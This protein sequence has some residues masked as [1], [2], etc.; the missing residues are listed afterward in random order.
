VIEW[1]ATLSVLVLKVATP[2]LFRVCVLN[3]EVPSM[4]VTVPVGVPS[5]GDAVVT[6]AVSVTVCWNE[7]GFG[8]DVS[9][10]EVVAWLTTWETA[11]DVL[12]PK[13]VLPP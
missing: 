4:K 3:A 2:A 10:V 13:L 8:S 5:P 9:A 12:D 1:V 6:V 7:L 11:V